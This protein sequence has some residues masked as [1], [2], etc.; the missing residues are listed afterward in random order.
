MHKADMERMQ[1]VKRV[2]KVRR[3]SADVVELSPWQ[4]ICP[5]CRLVAHVRKKHC[6]CGYTFPAARRVAPK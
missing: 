3:T 4:K 2:V 5:R 1:R 6:S